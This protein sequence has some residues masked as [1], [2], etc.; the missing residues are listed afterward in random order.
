ME[1][2]KVPYK[3]KVEPIFSNDPNLGIVAQCP[4]CQDTLFQEDDGEYYCVIC[5]YAEAQEEKSKHTEYDVIMFLCPI[6]DKVLFPVFDKGVLGKCTEHGDISTS[7]WGGKPH[8]SYG[9]VKE[10]KK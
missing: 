2:L 6:C 3:K 1:A 5:G 4:V 8:V 9:K 7:Q 10:K